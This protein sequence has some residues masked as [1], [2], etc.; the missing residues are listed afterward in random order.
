ADAQEEKAQ[1][2][3]GWRIG[4]VSIAGIPLPGTF[5]RALSDLGWREGGNIVFEKRYV[6]SPTEI[7]RAA[8]E[9]VPVRADIILTISGGNGEQILKATKTAPIIVL[10]SG[11]LG[12]S[13]LRQPEPARRKPHGDA[14]LL[15][16][17]HGQAPSASEGGLARRFAPRDSPPESSSGRTREHLSPNDR[18]DCEQAWHENS[19]RGVREAGDPEGPFL[20]DDQ[21]T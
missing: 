18:R 21:G 20:S 13:G 8:E 15:A 9:L 14:D 19:L 12:S 2:G 6:S 3:K 7:Q 4:W 1:A 17:A 11:E 10:S 5:N 16:R